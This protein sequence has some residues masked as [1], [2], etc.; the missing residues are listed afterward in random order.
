MFGKAGLNAGDWCRFPPRPPSLKCAIVQGATF[1]SVQC[2]Q[3]ISPMEARESC[4]TSMNSDHMTKSPCHGSI[5]FQGASRKGLYRIQAD[6]C[7]PQVMQNVLPCQRQ[8]VVSIVQP[9]THPVPP[10][11][12][13]LCAGRRFLRPCPRSRSL[14]R[15]NVLGVILCSRGQTLSARFDAG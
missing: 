14:L 3:S 9:L 6:R 5:A 12:I 4:V 1:P 8:L 15:S 13:G 10:P 7:L 11:E 2:I